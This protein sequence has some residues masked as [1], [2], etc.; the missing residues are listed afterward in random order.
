MKAGKSTVCDGLGII[1][2]RDIP[3]GTLYLDL[4]LQ[5]DVRIDSFTFET[6][7]LNYPEF[8]T[9]LKH[10]GFYS[11]HSDQLILSLDYSRY[12]NHS[13]EAPTGI[14]VDDG[15]RQIAYTLRDIKCGEE[16]FEDYREYNGCPW[17]TLYEDLNLEDSRDQNDL[18]TIDHE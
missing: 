17:V 15:K 11:S 4:E 16:L 8:V 6:L 18:K 2:T 3:K 7:A 13:A 1:A 5:T 10:F 9:V 12:M 14:Y